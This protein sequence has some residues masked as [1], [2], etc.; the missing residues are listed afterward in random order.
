MKIV[1]RLI[2]VLLLVLAVPAVLVAGDV[3][4]P[5]PPDFSHIPDDALVPVA[6][7]AEGTPGS[8]VAQYHRRTPSS[9]GGPRTSLQGPPDGRGGGNLGGLES[10]QFP[11]SAR[12]SATTLSGG[13]LGQGDPTIITWSI[14]PD[15]TS[16]FGYNGEPTS[17]SNLR[18]FLSSIYGSQAV[19]LPLF[20]QVFDRWGE[21]TGVTYV[22]E[23]NDDGSPWTSTNIAAG[24][25]GVRGD[26]RISGHTIDG[27]SGVLAY[28][29][30]PNFGDMVIDTA[31]NT[32]TNLANNSRILRN[33]LAHEHGH[34]LGISH[35][36]PVNQTKLMEP[37]LSTAFDG[38]QLDDIL[39]ANRGYGDSLEHNDSPGT[40]SGLGTF[41]PGDTVMLGNRSV[42]DNSDPDFLSFT[43]GSGT[44]ASVTINPLGS[45]YLSGPQNANGSCSAGT[46]FNALNRQD[47]GLEILDTN[48]TTVLASANATGAGGSESLSNVALPGA[49]TYFV[50]VDGP[51]NEAQ[52]Y[53]FDLGIG[54]TGGGA[55]VGFANVIIDE[56]LR[57]VSVSG[58]STP[59][60]VMGPPSFAGSHPSTIRVRNVGATSF[61]HNLQ[62]WDYL[63]GGHVLEDIGYL[64]LDNGAQSLGSLDAEAGSASVDEA[65]VTVSFTQSFTT[66]PVV[67]GQVASFNGSQAAEVRIRNVSSSGFQIRV[68]EEEGN[69]DNHAFERVDWIAVEPGTTTF[70]GNKLVVGLTGDSVT[71][72]WFTIS[73]STVNRPVF[74]AEMQTFDGSDPAALRHRSLSSTSVQVKVEEE[75]SNDTETNHTTE[76]VGYLVIGS[77]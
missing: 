22:F 3:P 9:A 50:R 69:D 63:D 71:H 40:A 33:V 13:G 20:Q 75:Q 52:L 35:V 24:Q 47:L 29:F 65:W 74:L 4:E 26:V 6:C 43:V 16:I 8:L 70:G 58:F 28:N 59:R 49:G 68:Q 15:G 18:A 60:V 41:S 67:L 77:P 62:E 31:D 55:N 36:C 54:A 23:P 10:F 73:Y 19:W 76:V 30:F 56:V 37:F 61:Q 46:N 48:G 1:S 14:V 42:D 57:T 2:P 51:N 27:T 12:W 17:P 66:T 39:A 53:E 44:N 5:T 34:G 7:F 64:V 32:Y 38:P 21:L 11:D 72:D 25:A 45:T